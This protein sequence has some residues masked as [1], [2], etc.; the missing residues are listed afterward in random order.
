M[1]KKFTF[2][3]G[4]PLVVFGQSTVA[5][6]FKGIYDMLGQNGADSLLYTA[7]RKTGRS[8]AEQQRKSTEKKRIELLKKCTEGDEGARWGKFEYAIDFETFEGEVRLYDSFLAKSWIEN[9]ETEQK[10]PVCAFIAGY[11]AGIIESIF[12]KRV[13]VEEKECMALGND[14]CVF[15]LR[16]GVLGE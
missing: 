7:G 14:Y 9:I 5:N 2:E 8:Y 16:K 1:S 13:I 10:Y 3:T 11:I 4:I 12:G 6:I 15:K